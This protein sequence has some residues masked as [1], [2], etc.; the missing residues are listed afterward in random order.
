[1]SEAEL[2][3][4]GAR[5]FGRPHIAAAMLRKG[6]VRTLQDAYAGYLGRGR[7]AYVAKEIFSTGEAVSLL[8]QAG[9]SPFLAHPFFLRVPEADLETLVRRLIPLGL[10]GIEAYHSEHDASQER[11]LLNLA[12]R[13]GI[14]VSGGSD[15]HGAAKPAV[16][17]GRGRGA[18]HVPLSVL[19]R[20]KQ[21]RREQG[22][23]LSDAP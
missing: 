2:H 1:V 16:E 7:A 23:P 14:L 9:A 17:L 8:A 20:L 18:L 12:A 22:L 19:E 3:D 5:V 4:E 10:T 11:R 6:Y 13:C 21:H 15:F